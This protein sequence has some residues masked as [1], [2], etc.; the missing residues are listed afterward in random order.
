MQVAFLE[1]PSFALAYIF[2]RWPIPRFFAFTTPLLDTEA[3]FFLDTLHLISLF[4]ALA[5]KSWPL[6]SVFYRIEALPF[7]CLT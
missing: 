5:G 2:T 6:I 3:Y 7:S 1:E 4:V